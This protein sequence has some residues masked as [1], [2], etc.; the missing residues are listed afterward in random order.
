MRL[1]G[2]LWLWGL[3][4]GFVGGF[5]D[6]WLFLQL[7]IDFRVAGRDMTGWIAVYLAVTFAVLCGAIGWF[8]DARA[9]ARRDA[10]T[11]REQWEAL[12]ASRRAA[13]QNEKLAAIGRLAA[14][15]A[16]EVR[17][18]LGVIRASASMVQE[19][20]DPDDEAH[21]ACGFICEETDRL[22]GLISSLLDFA[23]PASPR[24][25][26]VSLEKLIDRALALEAG[27]LE[28]R[29][30]QVTREA[31]PGL[32]ELVGD[33]D[34]LCQLLLGLVTNAAEALGQGGRI[35]LR[36]EADGECLRIEVADDGPGISLEQA[37]RI[38]EPFYTTKDSGTGIGLAMTAHII[39]AHGGTIQVLQGRGA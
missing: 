17:N 33:P 27:D 29:G 13:A 1:R 28:R 7:G 21:R 5:A 25:Q 8:I 37:E 26:S 35:G 20:F 22:N 14:G 32:A 16:H 34:Q 19:S 30:I 15:V 6:T 12:E 10:R 11:I 18:P 38:F 4:I 24:L 9:R 2:R 36:S 31:G 3:A 39:H 23:R